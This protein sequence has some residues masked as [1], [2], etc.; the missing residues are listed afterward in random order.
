LCDKNVLK[1]EFSLDKLFLD[2]LTFV[3]AIEVKIKFI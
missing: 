3:D 1:S 2:I